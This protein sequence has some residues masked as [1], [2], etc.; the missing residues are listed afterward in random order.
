[1]TASTAVSVVTAEPTPL[2][3]APQQPAHAAATPNCAQYA[4][5]VAKYAWNVATALA[6]MRAESGCDPNAYNG[7]NSDGSNDAG[8][9]QVNSIHVR[10]GLITD[11]G[12]YDPSTNIAAAYKIYQDRSAR[13]GDGWTAWSTYTSGRY[14]RWM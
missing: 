14:K 13:A 1:M 10:S 3:Q 2:A 12:R 4:N 5:L 11:A 9:F 8:L 6:V 7:A